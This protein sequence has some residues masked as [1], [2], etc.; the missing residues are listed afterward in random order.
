MNINLKKTKYNYL[1]L[2]FV[3]NMLIFFSGCDKDAYSVS[4]KQL[5]EF[6]EGQTGFANN[7]PTLVNDYVYIGTSRGVMYQAST[8]NAFYKLDKDLN[9]VWKYNLGTNEVMGAASLDSD[10][11]IYFIMNEGKGANDSFDS[12]KLVSL[13]NSGTFRWSRMI[14]YY[15]LS[16]P[17]VWGGISCPAISTDDVIYA[18][19]N[20]FYAFD[21]N[22]VELWHYMADNGENPILT[23]P[24]IDPIG[25]IYFRTGYSLISIDKNGNERWKTT[26]TLA[27]G[28]TSNQAFSVDYSKIYCTST[29]TKSLLCLNANDGSLVWQYVINDMTG[30]FRNTPAVDDNNNVYFGTH[31]EYNGDKRQTLYAVKN[32]GSSLLWKNNLGSDLYSSPALGSD[33]ML[34][35]G[36]E[37]H[38]NTSN[39]NNRLHAINMANGNISW[40]A[41]LPKDVTW[42]SPAIGNNGTLYI[43]TMDY[44]GEGGGVFSFHTNSTGLL[45]NAGSPRFQGG[46]ASN[47]R[48]E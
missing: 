7:P 2:F 32:D 44:N 29:P 25:N 19:G 14:W 30:D 41:N 31:G 26:A 17:F 8:D 24:I 5:R 22:G 23:A 18:G 4:D 10:G 35:I 27:A 20:N 36:S 43:A 40:S 37:G 34:Y 12:L 3:I 45:A 46:N 42:S 38:G 9:K 13:T 39:N 47:G 33:R 16:I 48:R 21:K 28:G 15:N 6:K 11:N 1:L